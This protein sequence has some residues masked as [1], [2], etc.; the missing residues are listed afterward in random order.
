M[1][2]HSRRLRWME[3]Q[4]AET[5]LRFKR[6]TIPDT[7]HK[8][9]PPFQPSLRGSASSLS[10]GSDSLGLIGATKEH[11]VEPQRRAELCWVCHQ[12]KFYFAF[13][14]IFMHL[15][16]VIN[17][18]PCTMHACMVFGQKGRPK[19]NWDS[20][21]YT[22]YP[23]NWKQMHFCEPT[24]HAEKLT[25]GTG[26]ALVEQRDVSDCLSTHIYS[27][28]ALTICQTGSWIN[29]VHA[30]INYFV[31]VFSRYIDF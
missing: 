8:S 15:I 1:L 2:R 20:L 12:H 26:Y 22:L 4:S 5:P 3:Y 25:L 18:L 21:S 13:I 23:L 9:Y 24:I 19:I 29:K 11:S 30:S 6:A 16:C 28:S 10:D 17:C 27:R 31:F 7:T 14:I